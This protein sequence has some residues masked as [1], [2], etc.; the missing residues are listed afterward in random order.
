MQISFS[1]PLLCEDPSLPNTPQRFTFP[2]KIT[3]TDKNDFANHHGNVTLNAKF[4]PASGS[5]V[6]CSATVALT[7]NPNPFIKHGDTT[8]NPPE[9]WYLSQDI[10][11]FQVGASS[12]NGAFGAT[13]QS[14][15]AVQFIQDVINNLRNNASGSRAAFDAMS[16]DEDAETLA[17]AQ[18]D[19]NGF[20]V[21]NFAVARIRLR[22]TQ[23]APAVGAFFRI[24]SAQ[25]TGGSF[26]YNA[27]T[28]FRSKP[29]TDP[30]H[31]GDLIPVLGLDS[32][33][34][35]LSIPCFASAR[36]AVNLKLDAQSDSI[37]RITLNSTPPE[38]DFFFG[39]WLDINQSGDPRYP[40]TPIPLSSPEGPFGGAGP[41]PILNFML[42]GHQCL[43]V[44]ISF[45]PDPIPP[46]SDP[47]T[48]DKLAQRNLAFVSAPNPGLPG[49]RR[50]P[51]P[52]EVKPTAR[53]LA[54][55]LSTDE[56]MIEWRNLPDGSFAEVFLPAANAATILATANKLYTLHY[57]EQI[58]AH[59]LR[60]PAIGVTYLPVPSGI[61][62]TLTGLL[63]VDLPDGIRKGQTFEAVIRQ[64]SSMRGYRRGEDYARTKAAATG[65]LFAWKRTIGQFKLT[66]PV[67]TKKL[68]LPREEQ[69]LSI[70]KWIALT[71]PTTDRW[72]PVLTRYI[73][74]LS[75]RVTFMN[76][77]PAEVLPSGTGSWKPVPVHAHPFGDLVVGK[78]AGV[79]F[80]AF[81]DF[82]GFWLENASGA[83][84]RFSSREP[85]MR[86]LVEDAFDERSRVGVLMDKQRPDHAL[87]MV[88]ML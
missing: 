68:L 82:E 45:L 60:F 17:L 38:T 69:L 81:G 31:T 11:V 86:H 78:V 23:N 74:Q 32:S 49:S 16:Q 36:V 18:I 8:L 75:G 6:H 71:K 65:N 53:K 26:S 27:S 56:L 39:C 59:T 5:A 29:S 37:N 67:S 20:P 50:V 33:G 42:A 15:N 34:N 87:R 48:T 35:I 43:I 19:L 40:Q 12:G 28:T 61:E 14:G 13:L 84:Y 88:I 51:Q 52:F 66:I 9:P 46:N 41:V 30:S 25:A 24:V 54:F 70:M 79:I 22:D 1:G 21:Y 85:N 4:T 7:P 2:Y 72:Y 64:I 62:T 76:G 83:F 55:G 44:E 57:L 3:F 58:D 73:E 80:D 63:T 10:R 47:S 77:N